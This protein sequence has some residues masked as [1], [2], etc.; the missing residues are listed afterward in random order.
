[1]NR[2]YITLISYRRKN[3]DESVTKITETSRIGRFSLKIFYY[4]FHHKLDKTNNCQNRNQQGNPNLECKVNN[5]NHLKLVIGI[6]GLYTSRENIKIGPYFEVLGTG[7]GARIPILSLVAKMASLKKNLNLNQETRYT[8]YPHPINLRLKVFVY[9]FKVVEQ[10]Y[11]NL[12]ADVFFKFSPKI[13][14]TWFIVF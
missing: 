6:D 7:Y 4:Q 2:S 13:G 9:L 10:K 8:L 5:Q 3:I 14:E 11:M 1:M 12:S